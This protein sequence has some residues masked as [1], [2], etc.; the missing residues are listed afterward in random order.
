MPPQAT[1]VV[2]QSQMNVLELGLRNMR[3][4]HL[5]TMPEFI[6]MYDGIMKHFTDVKIA[7]LVATPQDTMEHYVQDT[8]F[9][10]LLIQMVSEVLSHQDRKQVRYLRQVYRWYRHNKHVLHSGPHFG[11]Q[12]KKVEKMK[13]A[14][15]MPPKAI[16]KLAG[17]KDREE[18]HS[19][20]QDVEVSEEDHAEGT[21][22]PPPSLYSPHSVGSAGLLVKTMQPAKELRPP[23]P[24][25]RV[26]PT[27]PD[28]SSPYSLLTRRAKAV[29]KGGPTPPPVNLEEEKA[30]RSAAL[31]KWE[32]YLNTTNFGQEQLSKLQYVGRSGLPGIPR[33]TAHDRCLNAEEFTQSIIDNYSLI[34]EMTKA[35]QGNAKLDKLKQDLMVNVSLHDFYSRAKNYFPIDYPKYPAFQSRIKSAPPPEPDVG[36]TIQVK[37]S[38]SARVHRHKKDN[39]PVTNVKLNTIVGLIDSVT[40]EMSVYKEKMTPDPLPGFRQPA[41]KFNPKKSPPD[42]PTRRC[43]R[44]RHVP[45]AQQWKPAFLTETVDWRG[46]ITAEPRKRLPR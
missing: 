10:Y 29:D 31:K 25:R 2:P 6:D 17:K 22:A 45:P 8:R 35:Q 1:S 16:L 39:T 37:R 14:L 12:R 40:E 18:K 3:R 46:R 28:V 36:F 4:S 7:H 21:D 30:Y 34:D 32:E 38:K 19:D 15:G 27:L 42:R 9:F 23:S 33:Y 13:R 26:Q 41:I 44:D 20:Q 43:T 24:V 5:R 11:K